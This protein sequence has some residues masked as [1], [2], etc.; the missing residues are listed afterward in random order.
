LCNKE[1]KA[2]VGKWKRSIFRFYYF[3]LFPFFSLFP[4]CT[5]PGELRTDTIYSNFNLKT[6]RHFSQNLQKRKVVKLP[7]IDNKL[8]TNQ[9][10]TPFPDL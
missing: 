4:V 9:W 10:V 5:I 7:F 1:E 3:L 6:F 8:I 2:K